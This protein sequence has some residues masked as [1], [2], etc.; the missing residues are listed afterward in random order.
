MKDESMQRIGSLTEEIRSLDVEIN[1]KRD[2]LEQIYLNDLEYSAGSYVQ[3]YDD[4]NGCF[5]FM[6]V[7]SIR[8]KNGCRYGLLSGPKITLHENPLEMEDPDEEVTW[9]EYTD[10]GSLRIEAGNLDGT[11]ASELSVITKEDFTFVLDYWVRNM[12]RNFRVKG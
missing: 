2:E 1:K 5:D 10:D 8:V 11:S 12:K 4:I 6:L 3:F 7:N 9:G